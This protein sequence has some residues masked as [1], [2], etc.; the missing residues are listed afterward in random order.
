MATAEFV[1]GPGTQSTSHSLVPSI[2]TIVGHP[3][4]DINGLN[5]DTCDSRKRPLESESEGGMATKRTNL[6]PGPVDDNKYMLKMLIP[7]TAAG[8]IIGKGGQT[9]AQLQ[10][11]TGTNVKLSKAN[12]FYPE[13][14][15]GRVSF[16][17]TEIAGIK[18]GELKEGRGERRE[19]GRYK[20]RRK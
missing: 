10:K 13:G 9:I 8:S 1:T 17:N 5:G 12:D 4:I 7:S 19:K 16:I 3:I 6:G 18:H 2:H 15:Q 11:D 14:N 20:K